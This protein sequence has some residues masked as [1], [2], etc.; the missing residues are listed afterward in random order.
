[1]QL[2]YF[3][4]FV[5]YSRYT[6]VL[7]RKRPLAEDLLWDLWQNGRPLERYVEEFIEL[8]HQLTPRQSPLYKWIHPFLPSGSS[9]SPKMWFHCA[10]LG[11][12]VADQHLQLSGQC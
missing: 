12:K 8:S 3:L 2:H 4:L 1:M 5:E 9:L 6:C 10:D 7:S 11:T